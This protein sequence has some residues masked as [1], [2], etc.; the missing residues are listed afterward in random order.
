MFQPVT[1][2]CHALRDNNVLR[3]EEDD[4]RT[5]ALGLFR[6]GDGLF[7]HLLLGGQRDDRHTVGD[8]ADG[9]VLELTGSVGVRVENIFV[10]YGTSTL[11]S[12]TGSC[13]IY[14]PGG[15]PLSFPL[16]SVFP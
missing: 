7:V 12:G 5:A 9:A 15:K 8:E 2:S 6:I 13:G 1:E 16:K 11:V 4:P 14:A 10:W 3:R